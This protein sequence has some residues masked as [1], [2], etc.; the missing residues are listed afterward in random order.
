[1]VVYADLFAGFCYCFRI[2][3]KWCSGVF[4]QQFHGQLSAEME[5]NALTSTLVGLRVN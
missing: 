5:L 1:M 4:S 2:W 3:A